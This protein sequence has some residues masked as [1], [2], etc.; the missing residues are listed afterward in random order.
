M[1]VDPPPN[2]AIADAR[3][4]SLPADTTGTLIGASKESGQ[5]R[6]LCGDS[7]AS[8]WYRITAPRR[9]SVVVELDNAG[10]MDGTVDIFRRERSRLEPVTCAATDKNGNATLEADGLDSG[11]D[12]LVRVGRDEGSVAD[13]F[14][15]RVLV[16]SP[17][18]TPPGRRLPGKGAR[19]VVD[20]ALDPG[21]AWNTFLTAG[22][23]TR[24]SLSSASCTSLQIFR[25]GVRSFERAEPVLSARCGGYRLFTPRTSGRFVFLVEAARGR[26]PQSY[27]LDVKPAGN[28]DTAPGVPLGDRA[29]VKGSL[30]GRIDSVDLYRF[31]VTQRAAVRLRV[32]GGDTEIELR[33]DGGRF[34]GD[35]P[36]VDERLRVG[37]YYVAVK[38]KGNYTLT[39]KSRT[40]TRSTVAFDGRKKAVTG[41][42]ARSTVALRVRPGVSGRGRVTIERRDPLSGWQFVRTQRLRVVAGSARFSFTPSALGRYRA[43]GEFAETRTLA[44]SESGYAKL[45]VAEPLGR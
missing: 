21:D 1:A 24:V 23:T 22:A 35:G 19:N 40:I 29:R 16:P 10:A 31:S 14:A 38:G 30:N 15:L 4:L 8:V 32:T 25:P 36:S 7:A 28:D 6:S 44:G 3:R 34:L 33:R 12:Y 11:T 2:D 18:P 41:P 9:G 39:R 37:R 27:R 17:P 26:G 43:W 20:R 42:G 5:D 13:T 45:R